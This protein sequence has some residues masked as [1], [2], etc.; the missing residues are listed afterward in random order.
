MFCC[1]KCL[2]KRYIILDISSLL[3]D[4]TGPLY[5]H[6][7]V[8]LCVMYVK[9]CVIVSQ[10]VKS[11]NTHLYGSLNS[12]PLSYKGGC[13]IIIMCFSAFERKADFACR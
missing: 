7:L 9:I 2:S 11:Y 12:A 5:I 6:M 10:A 4:L 8:L 13:G 1:T 3:K